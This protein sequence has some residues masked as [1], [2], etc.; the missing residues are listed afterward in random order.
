MWPADSVDK[1]LQVADRESHFHADVYN[2]WCCYG[3]FQINGASHLARLRAKGLTVQDLF[4][5]RVNIE[6]ALELFNEQGWAP[7]GG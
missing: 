2:G 7:W 5:P 4:D 3:V 6:L 1:A